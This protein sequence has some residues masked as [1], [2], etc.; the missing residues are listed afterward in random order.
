MKINPVTLLF[1]KKTKQLCIK[2]KCMDQQA[3]GVSLDTA[4]RK[5]DLIRIAHT[6]RY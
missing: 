1:K 2:Q 6:V 3:A 5:R 4:V